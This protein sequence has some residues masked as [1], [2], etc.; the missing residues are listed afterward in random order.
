MVE[1]GHP[2]ASACAGARRA[3]VCAGTETEGRREGLLSREGCAWNPTMLR[4]CPWAPAVKAERKAVCEAGH[5][6]T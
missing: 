2:G 1:T 3:S 4:V 5:Q 6:A